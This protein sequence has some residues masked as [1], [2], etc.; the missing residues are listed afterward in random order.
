VYVIIRKKMKVSPLS[1]LSCRIGLVNEMALAEPLDKVVNLLLMDPVVFLPALP[2]VVWVLKV[3]TEPSRE[4]RETVSGLTKRPNA[5]NILSDVPSGLLKK[6][7][8]SST[9]SARL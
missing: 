9:S 8:A 6:N 1:R 4:Q 5:W 2:R 3:V 7:L